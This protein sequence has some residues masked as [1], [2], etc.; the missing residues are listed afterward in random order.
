MIEK[1]CEGRRLRSAS[2]KGSPLQIVQH[3]WLSVYPLGFSQHRVVWWTQHPTGV[4]MLARNSAS[5]WTVEALFRTRVQI[6]GENALLVFRILRNALKPAKGRCGVDRSDPTILD[7][8]STITT[9]YC[10]WEPVPNENRGP[11]WR[12]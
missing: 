12:D 9:P 2:R 11:F 1:R 8:H 4:Y 3:S 5:F 7:G 6:G 10:A